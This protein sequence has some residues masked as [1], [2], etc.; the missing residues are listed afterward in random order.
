MADVVRHADLLAKRDVALDLLVFSLGRVL[1][2]R[3]VLAMS[4]DDLAERL[5]SLHSLTHK[6]GIVHA[7]TV[8]RE[9]ANVGSER[10]NIRE[11]K[12]HLAS[13][14]A[15]E[16]ENLDLSVVVYYIQLLLQ[17]FVAVGNGVE[18]RHSTD[19]RVSSSCRRR[20][21]CRNSLFIRKTRLSKMHVHIDKTGKNNVF[22]TVN[23]DITGKRCLGDEGG[24]L[25]SCGVLK[26]NRRIRKSNFHFQKTSLICKYYYLYYY[27]IS[28]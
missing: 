1:L 2:L 14:Y 9:A 12:S 16:G 19:C 17:V 24:I 3:A 20:A 25:F 4:R 28:A 21:T 22:R 13:R 11:S 27:T 5:C 6:R 18:I 26:N 23:G 8:V 7:A 10:L 15:S